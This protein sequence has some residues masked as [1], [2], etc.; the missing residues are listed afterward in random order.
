V[1]PL[2]ADVRYAGFW[3]R[4]LAVLVDLFLINLLLLPLTWWVYGAAAFTPGRP[5]ILGGADVLLNMVA[6]LAAGILFWRYR[7]ATPGKMMLGL[8]IVDAASHGPLT[9]RQCAQ[10]QL[11]YLVS[12]LPLG[13]GFIS[14]AWD[15]HKQGWHDKLAHTQVIYRNPR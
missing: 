1:S 5:M 10:R 14:I 2:R 12:S 6:P 4:L 8:V 9:W 3:V 11:A 15:G 13:L 7:A